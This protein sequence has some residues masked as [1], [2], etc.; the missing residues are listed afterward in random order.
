MSEANRKREYDRLIKLNKDVPEVLVK[1]FGATK[2]EKP[3]TLPKK[4]KK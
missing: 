2:V 4:E 3:N 1:E